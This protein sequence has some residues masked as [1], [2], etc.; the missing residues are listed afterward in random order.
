MPPTL[1]LVFNL[2]RAYATNWLRNKAY[3]LKM[4]N[5]VYILRLAYKYGTS[6]QKII[7]IS[8]GV[9]P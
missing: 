8:Q 1:R 4:K 3:T 2:T 5:T 6:V 9:M 7:T